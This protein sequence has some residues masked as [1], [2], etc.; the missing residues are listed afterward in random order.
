MILFVLAVRDLWQRVTKILL[1][2]K[3]TLPQFLPA[4]RT[5]IY[6]HACEQLAAVTSIKTSL[7]SYAWRY[8][9]WDSD[10]NSSA[11]RPALRNLRRCCLSRGLVHSTARACVDVNCAHLVDFAGFYTAAIVSTCNLFL[12]VVS[13]AADQSKLGWRVVGSGFNGG[14]ARVIHCCCM[15]YL[16]KFTL[17]VD[18]E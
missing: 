7:T 6:V 8:L 13:C 5:I 16:G 15:P 9:Y 14:W 17:D 4:T 1:M 2:L 11:H 18:R 12:L 10:R 3:V